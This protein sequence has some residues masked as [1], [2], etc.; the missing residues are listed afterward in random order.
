MQTRR[1]DGWPDEN[2]PVGVA[3]LALLIARLDCHR[4]NRD[5]EE[6]SEDLKGSRLIC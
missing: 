5:Q 4:C 6:K 1:Y 3:A 2:V